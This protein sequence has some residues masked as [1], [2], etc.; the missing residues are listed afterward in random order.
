MTSHSLPQQPHTDAAKN[1][2]KGLGVALEGRPRGIDGFGRGG[3]GRKGWTISRP[4]GDL[5]SELFL[6]PMPSDDDNG[7]DSMLAYYKVH[8]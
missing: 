4:F 3:T 5:Y 8:F 1:E 6:L 2:G 7:A